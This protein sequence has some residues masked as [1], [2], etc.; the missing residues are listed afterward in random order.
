MNIENII[1]GA[2]AAI[3]MSVVNKNEKQSLHSSDGRTE[4]EKIWDFK[5]SVNIWRNTI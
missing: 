1:A 3:L 5:E 2:A 4:S